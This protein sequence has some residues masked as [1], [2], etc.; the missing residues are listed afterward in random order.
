MYVA[1]VGLGTAVTLS[2]LGE[3]YAWLMPSWV[4]LVVL[5]F[6]LLVRGTERYHAAHLSV[7]ALAI[8]VAVPA[9][10]LLVGYPGV[11]GGEIAVSAIAATL[12]VWAACALAFLVAKRNLE[13]QED[14]EQAHVEL[15][16]AEEAL[17][18]FGC[19][20]LERKLSQGGMGEVWIGQ[21][22]FLKRP[23]AIKLIRHEM[24]RNRLASD[25]AE[26]LG[27]TSSVDDILARFERE[28]STI[29]MLTSPNTVQIYD[30]GRTSGGTFFYV[31]E[32]LHGIDL[33]RFVRT[34]GPMPQERVA[35][36]L[37]QA[38]LSLAEAHDAGFAHRDIKPQNL[39]LTR[40][41]VQYDVLKVL[42]FGLV[43]DFLGANDPSAVH[44]TAANAVCGTPSF[45]AP[46]QARG[47]D[48]DH[49]ADLYSLGC[50]A[51]YLLTGTHVFPAKEPLERILAHVQEPPEPIGRRAPRLNIHP[52]LDRLVIRCL[53]KD[54]KKRMQSAFELMEVLESVP[55]SRPWTKVDARNWAH[56]HPSVFGERRVER[57]STLTPPLLRPM[58]S[59]FPGTVNRQRGNGAT[60]QHP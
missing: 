54:P 29:A 38:C 57:I 11:S 8:P 59:V 6:A 32:L 33:Q 14:L 35:H 53:E 12:G 52:E 47:R 28:A 20:T 50:V 51:Y 1:L 5:G 45:M 16:E 58:A 22:V 3:P 36:L 31:M 39:F 56:Q 24:L 34:F 44:L 30:Y 4:A 19:Y 41:G 46:E 23:A 43:L 49:R 7:A 42:D 15:A 13:Q 18:R 25:V 21:H 2:Y 37:V 60:L 26:E 40:Q 10:S 55:F 9:Y 27:N 48:V 17:D